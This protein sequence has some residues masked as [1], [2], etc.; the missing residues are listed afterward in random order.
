MY[1]A[2]HNAGSDDEFDS[3][4]DETDH[5]EE[6]FQDLEENLA[7]VIADVHDLALFTKLNYTGFLKIVKKHDK[8][9]GRLLRKEFVQHYLSTRPF[10]N[11]LL[12]TSPSPR[13]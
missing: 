1:Q 7:N 8:Q 9:T 5:F 2:R 13:D 12:Y 4:S 11:C 6:R 10:Y 3:D